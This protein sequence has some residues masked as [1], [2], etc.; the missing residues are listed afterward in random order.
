MNRRAALA[1][2]ISIACTAGLASANAA[3]SPEISLDIERCPALPRDEVLR[4]AA[5]ELDARI[6]PSSSSSSSSS[7]PKPA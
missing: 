1:A 6:V 5:L 2:A 4:L 3:P 7:P